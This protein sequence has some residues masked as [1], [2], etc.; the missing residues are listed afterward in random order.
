MRPNVNYKVSDNLAV[1]TG[2]NV[3]FGDYPNTFFG[4]FQNNT[5]IYTGLRYS[6]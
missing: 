5:N 1:E 4:Q 3:S 6:F 2:A